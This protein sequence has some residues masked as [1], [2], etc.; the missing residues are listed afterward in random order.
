M[1]LHLISVTSHN[2]GPR[3][4]VKKQDPKRGQSVGSYSNWV[5][6]HGIVALIAFVVCPCVILCDCRNLSLTFFWLLIWNRY[7]GVAFASVSI[8]LFI[9][10]VLDVKQFLAT[11]L[12]KCQIRESCQLSNGFDFAGRKRF[13]NYFIKIIQ[14]NTNNVAIKWI[15]SV[16]FLLF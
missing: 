14:T 16:V 3:Q 4:S 10:S 9:L 15:F 13:P 11:L 12:F 2:N 1:K 8:K 6:E 5:V 7:E